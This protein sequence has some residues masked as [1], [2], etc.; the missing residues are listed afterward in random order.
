MSL[1]D[2]IQSDNRRVFMNQNHFADTHTWNGKPFLCV[3]DEEEAIRLNLWELDTKAVVVRVNKD[4]WPGRAVVNE[5]GFFDNQNMR[6]VQ[7]G[8]DCGMYTI[9]LSSYWP[10]Q[11]G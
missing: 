5:S 4:D 1:K 8:E 3:T 7:I 11:M 10:G 2:K 6:I 9:L